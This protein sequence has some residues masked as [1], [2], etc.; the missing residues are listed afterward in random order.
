MFQIRAVESPE[1]DANRSEVGFHAQM[2]TSESWP[3]SVVARDGGISI[4]F[5]GSWCTMELFVVGNEAMTV[6]FSELN[7]GVGKV[8]GGACWIV[9]A[10][11]LCGVPERDTLLDWVEMLIVELDEIDWV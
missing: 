3:R 2:N 7:I 10:L 6:V 4:L 8:L 1:P 5:T 11:E 9:D